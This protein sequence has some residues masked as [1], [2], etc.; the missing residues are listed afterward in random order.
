M[1]PM[2]ELVLIMFML[3]FGAETFYIGSDLA[4]D[5]FKK[6]EKEKENKKDDAH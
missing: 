3:I 2:D 5:W 1:S 4:K 6:K